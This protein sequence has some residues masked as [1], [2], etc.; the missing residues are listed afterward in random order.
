[1]ILR[2]FVIICYIPFGIYR[3][4]ASIVYGLISHPARLD[5]VL[6]SDK[7]SNCFMVVDFRFG[8]FITSIIWGNGF[9]SRIMCSIR[10]LWQEEVVYRDT[11]CEYKD[12]AHKLKDEYGIGDGV[13]RPNGDKNK[14]LPGFSD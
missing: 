9:I 7:M 1:M 5:H 11:I 10:G 13:Y 14:D 8:Y 4:V 2:L 6:L 12:L 3:L